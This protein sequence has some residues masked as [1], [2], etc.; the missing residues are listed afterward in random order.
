[1]GQYQ[2]FLVPIAIISILGGCIPIAINNCRYNSNYGY[3]E[4]RAIEQYGDNLYPLTDQERQS[5]Y[6]DMGMKQGKEPKLKD[7]KKFL[8]E[9]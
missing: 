3:A 9:Q 1:M 2:D 7:L 8:D 4:K 6:N 5:W